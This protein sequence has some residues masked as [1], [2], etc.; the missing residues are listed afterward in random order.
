VLQPRA[1]G[2]RGWRRHATISVLVMSASFVGNLP[3]NG[4]AMSDMPGMEHHHDHG[5]AAVSQQPAAST[6]HAKR[7]SLRMNRPRGRRSTHAA[8]H[9]QQHE[10]PQH[11][12]HEMGAMPGMQRGEHGME[13]M[14]GMEHGQHGMDA[15]PGTEHGPHG[16]EAMPGMEHGGHELGAM[17]MQG[18]FGPYTM[19]REAS[20]TSWQ[21]DSTPHQGVMFMSGDW[22]LMA[23]ANLFGIYDHQG[24]P[25]GGSKTFA[26]GMVMAMAQ[27]PVGDAGTLG[28]RTMLSPDP[29]MGANGY[30][31]L[32]ATGETANGRTPLIDRQ[33]P[34]D[35]FMELSGSYSH[36]LSDTDSAF[37]YFGLPGEPALGPPAFMH[38]MSGMDNPEAPITHHWLDSTHI[39][40]GVLTGGLVR[41]NFKVEVSGF[42]G[43]EPDQHR[44]DI[45]APALDS[46]SIRLSW[47]PTPDLSA[48][49]SW[50]HLHSPEQLEPSVNENRL[51]ASVIYNKQFGEGNNWVTTLAWGRKMNHPGHTLDGFLLESAAV[52]AD[53]HTIFGRAERVDEDELLGHVEPIPVFTPTKFS[54]GYIYDFHVAEH[55]KFGIGGLASR[56]IVPKGLDTAYGSDPTSFMTFVRLKGY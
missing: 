3:A 11:G 23:H 15:M 13:A 25:R 47:N 55:V 26:A 43:R 42:R 22:M 17:H 18:Q 34:H 12:Q 14:P 16:T 7:R 41:D 56:Y 53:T 45:E 32:F 35:L 52:L 33:H 44:Y 40:F 30:P 48:Q 38:R 5:G 36:R 29:F 27:R 1:P 31:L 28:F 39:T 46:V 2:V 21:P 8:I 49:V 24:G 4:Q 6:P 19:S 10:T 51:T 20:G 37:L 54:L 50:G 9:A